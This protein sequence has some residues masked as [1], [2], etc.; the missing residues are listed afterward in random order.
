[1]LL[2][3]CHPPED[4][5]STQMI[6]F[7]TPMLMP[8]WLNYSNLLKSCGM[9]VGTWGEQDVPHYTLVN[10]QVKFLSPNRTHTQV[11]V[12]N[13]HALPGLTLSPASKGL[14]SFPFLSEFPPVL[15]PPYP[16]IRELTKRRRRRQRRRYKTI[17]LV[18]KNNGS[19]RSARAF[20][21]LVHFFAVIS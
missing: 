1:M 13:R 6:F 11:S 18:S 16:F 3:L 10:S 21:I 15:N 4:K 2:K 8:S 20:Y 7:P 14:L 19:V 5:N 12:H 9:G 17:G